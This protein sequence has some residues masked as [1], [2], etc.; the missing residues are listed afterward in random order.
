LCDVGSDTAFRA[1]VNSWPKTRRVVHTTLLIVGLYCASFPG[2]R[3]DYAPWSQAM[4]DFGWYI[5]PLGTTNYSKR[6]TAVGWDLMA[7][8]I[9]LSPT[10]QDLFSNKV[11][12]WIGRNSFSVYLTHGTLLRVVLVRFIYGWSTEP[13]SIEKVE[14]KDPI[15]H[16]IPKTESYF[17]FSLSIVVWFALLYTCAHLWTTYVDSWCA[18]ATKALED[19]MFESEDEKGGVMQMA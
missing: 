19:Y 1:F 4:M 7:T 14:G 5:F 2:E 9:W 12:M 17:V 11:F 13:F 8:G 3:P 16:W 6:W 18:K 15:F 10:L